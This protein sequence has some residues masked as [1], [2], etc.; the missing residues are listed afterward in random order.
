MRR[1]LGC[2][3]A[4]FC[5]ATAFAQPKM[6]MPPDYQVM[7]FVEEMEGE[8]TDA[9]TP[10]GTVT[11]LRLAFAKSP[12][13]WLPVCA[14]AGLEGDRP[15]CLELG[16]AGELGWRFVLRGAPS[17]E[18]RTRGLYDAT[19]PNLMGALNLASPAPRAGE[20]AA[21]WASW[22]GGEA[23]RPVLALRRPVVPRMAGWKEAP[24][25]PADLEA[26]VKFF[27]RAMPTVPSCREGESPQSGPA[28][29]PRH[30]EPSASFAS[31]RGE[32]FF[33]VR[34][35]RKLARDCEGALSIEWSDFWFY[36]KAGAPPDLIDLGL[37][38]EQ[39]LRMRLIEFGDFDGDGKPEAVFW[40]AS[41][42]E[43]GYVL[44]QDGFTRAVKAIWTYH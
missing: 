12:S 19:R 5:A 8:A 17:G 23:R 20:P 42:N 21:E 25:R 35:D 3:A 27:V 44:L 33:G 29:A 2:V 24:V 4:A 26:V 38:R 34:L 39:A 43:D 6:Q 1:V 32:R 41:P 14:I 16:A 13:G 10:A 18:L 15:Q 40:Q 28:L 22:M 7:G 11:K 36:A 37:S 30:W 31:A 9:S